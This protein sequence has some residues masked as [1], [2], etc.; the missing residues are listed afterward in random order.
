MP[1]GVSLSLQIE[2][3]GLVKFFLSSW[4]HLIL[5][6]LCYALGLCHSVKSCALPPSL[7]FLDLFLSLVQACKLPLPSL[8]GHQKIA[9]LWEGNTV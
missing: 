8:E 3:Q 4:T 7:L 6:H 5:I 9:G 1:L 2:N